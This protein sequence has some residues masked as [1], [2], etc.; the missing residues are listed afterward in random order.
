MI[1]NSTI[2]ENDI[3]YELNTTH[4]QSKSFGLFIEQL[5]IYV[6]HI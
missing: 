4:K 1:K 2:I 5:K 3:K 6:I